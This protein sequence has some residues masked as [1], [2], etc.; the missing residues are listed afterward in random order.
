MGESDQFAGGYLARRAEAGLLF[1]FFRYSCLRG[2]WALGGGH[3]SSPG[4]YGYFFFVVG[5]YKY[6]DKE[7]YGNLS[8]TQ[9]RFAENRNQLKISR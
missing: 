6:L 8:G 4:V 7:P 5:F 2:G 3:E 9:E 1:L